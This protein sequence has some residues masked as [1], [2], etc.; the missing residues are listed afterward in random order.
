MRLGFLV[1]ISS[2]L[3]CGNTPPPSSIVPIPETLKA[4][5]RRRVDS[6][7]NPSLAVAAYQDGEE[8]Y[9]VYGWQVRGEVH[10]CRKKCLIFSRGFRFQ[11]FSSKYSLPN[12]A[13]FWYCQNRSLPSFFS[14]F[15]KHYCGRKKIAKKFNHLY[16]L[17]SAFFIMS[18]QNMSSGAPVTES[19]EY[20]IASI[21]KTAVALLMGKMFVERRLRL[22]DPLENFLPGFVSAS[23]DNSFQHFKLHTIGNYFAFLMDCDAASCNLIF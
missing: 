15:Q 22:W 14:R 20:E 16:Q 13:I 8:D 9:Y 2:G 10:V 3:V 19:T 7:E 1:F 5:V 17:C 4:E 21:T 18:M 11:I 6:G 12:M 23:V